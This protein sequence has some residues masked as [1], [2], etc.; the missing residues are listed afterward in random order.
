VFNDHFFPQYEANG[1]Y[2]VTLIRIFIKLLNIDFEQRQTA[3]AIAKC[4]LSKPCNHKGITA[5]SDGRT[6]LCYRQ[7]T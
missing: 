5:R 3:N 6:Q 4:A 2:K 1:A 7:R